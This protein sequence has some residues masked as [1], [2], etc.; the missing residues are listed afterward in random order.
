M[1]DITDMEY[2]DYTLRYSTD[3]FG[4]KIVIVYGVGEFNT[5]FDAE[6]YIDDLIEQKNLIWEMLH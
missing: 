3:Y 6:R 1:Q 4:N 2:K 5:V